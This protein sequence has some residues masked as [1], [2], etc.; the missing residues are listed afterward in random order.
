MT[1]TKSFIT[2]KVQVIES[3]N[4]ACP[5][6]LK[7]CAWRP[8]FSHFGSEMTKISMSKLTFTCPTWRSSDCMSL[9]SATYL[10]DWIYVQTDASFKASKCSQVEGIWLPPF[11]RKWQPFLGQR[12]RALVPFIV[13]APIWSM[14]QQQS[15]NRPGIPRPHRLII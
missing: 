13:D 2:L 6:I 11:R 1:F 10:T 9:M 4:L 15:C 14:L 12:I 5:N 7:K 3:W 8:N